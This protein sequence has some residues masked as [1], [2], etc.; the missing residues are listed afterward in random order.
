[1]SK[2]AQNAS[3]G[4]VQQAYRS[5]ATD[6]MGISSPIGVYIG[7]VKRN[8]DNQNMGRLQVYIQDFGASTASTSRLRGT[9][10]LLETVSDW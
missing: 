8:D 10:K 6:N 7:I 3:Q 4:K 1:M 5:G 2:V 9:N